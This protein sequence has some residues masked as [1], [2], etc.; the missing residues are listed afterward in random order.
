MRISLRRV[1]VALVAVMAL[2]VVIPLCAGW[3]EPP[4]VERSVEVLFDEEERA[5]G[6][7]AL[8]K[9]WQKPEEAARVGWMITLQALKSLEEDDAEEAYAEMMELAVLWYRH[10]AEGG[11]PNAMV[12][13]IVLSDTMGIGTLSPE[14][15]EE[16]ANRAF[17]ALSTQSALSQDEVR[18]LAQCYIHGIGTPQDEQKGR[19]LLR[20]LEEMAPQF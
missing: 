19:H 6:R 18:S 5:Q 4:V 17:E 3:F 2:A 7:Y 13:L 8:E 14:Q 16:Y 9:S 11:E 12:R 20:Q 15:R 10:A 1:A